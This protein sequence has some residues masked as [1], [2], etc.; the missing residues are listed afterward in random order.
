MVYPQFLAQ[1]PR[2][3]PPQQQQKLLQYCRNALNLSPRGRM[4]MMMMNN[5]GPD[6]TPMYRPPLQLINTT[7]LYRGVRQRHWENGWLRFV[8][9]KIGLVSGWEHSTR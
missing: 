4:T 3:A 7:K 9:L 5:I 8:F 2:I 1:D 6:G